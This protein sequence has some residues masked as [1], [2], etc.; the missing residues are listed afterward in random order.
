MKD[1]KEKGFGDRLLTY[2]YK[3]TTAIDLLHKL[4]EDLNNKSKGEKLS[5]K[6]H[7]DSYK[8]YKNQ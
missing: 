2:T 3:L 1:Y 6:K 8:K 4:L 5:L 7:F